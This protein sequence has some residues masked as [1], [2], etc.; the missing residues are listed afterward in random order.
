[1]RQRHHAE[2]ESIFGRGA[3]CDPN[4]LTKPQREF[5]E[6]SLAGGALTM[7]A[8][9]HQIVYGFDGVFNAYHREVVDFLL[10]YTEHFDQ[11]SW[12]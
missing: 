5:A 3:R 7:P 11:E 9:L 4:L 8:T 2:D 1:M 10:P 6:I 12:W